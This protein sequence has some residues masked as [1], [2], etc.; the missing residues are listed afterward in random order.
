MLTGLIG[1]AIAAFP[2]TGPPSRT[3]LGAPALLAG[4]GSFETAAQDRHD[5]AS[6][7]EMKASNG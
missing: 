7:T 5:I 3:A 2:A 4:V 6:E 1:C